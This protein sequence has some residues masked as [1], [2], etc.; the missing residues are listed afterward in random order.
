MLLEENAGREKK[1]KKKNWRKSR[2]FVNFVVE[3]RAKREGGGGGQLIVHIKI[4]IIIL[5]LSREIIV[6]MICHC[7]PM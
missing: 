3:M 4:E 6:Y 5:N 7:S 2:I 1:K